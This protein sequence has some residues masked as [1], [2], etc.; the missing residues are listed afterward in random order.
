MTRQVVS[1]STQ[2]LGK[3]QMDVAFM[4]SELEKPVLQRPAKGE[5]D[6]REWSRAQLSVLLG[7]WRS[8]SSVSNP[9]G[10]EE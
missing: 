2:F 4:G 8:L 6:C 10:V 1:S 9:S 5:V 7:L 3:L